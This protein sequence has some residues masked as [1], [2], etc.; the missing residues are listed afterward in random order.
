[1]E[2][3]TSLSCYLETRLGGSLIFFY[4]QRHYIMASRKRKAKTLLT[5]QRL[6]SSYFTTES[7]SVIEETGQTSECQTPGLETSSTSGNS[8]NSNSK[9]PRRQLAFESTEKNS[10]RAATSN[11]SARKTTKP[12]ESFDK[13][14]EISET[15]KENVFCQIPIKDLMLNCALVCR[16]WHRIIAEPSVSCKLICQAM[17]LTFF[18]LTG[19][20]N[21]LG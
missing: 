13:F 3:T 5:G 11:K 7:D 12:P 1:M 10:S 21:Y 18:W 16:D 19:A 14:L 20:I 15:I 17:D 9:C 2:G 8:G 4:H 6:I